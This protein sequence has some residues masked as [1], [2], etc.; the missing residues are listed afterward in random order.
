[1]K[2]QTLQ[3]VND[4]LIDAG[5]FIKDVAEE[6]SKVQCLETFSQCQD[7]VQWLK[8]VARGYIDSL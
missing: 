5:K 8:N 2:D 7:I 4:S 1:M 6:P 3:D